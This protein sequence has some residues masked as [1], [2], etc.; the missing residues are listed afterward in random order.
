[1]CTHS[2]IAPY[3]ILVEL[4]SSIFFIILCGQFGKDF[5]QNNIFNY[6]DKVN[7]INK[8]FKQLELLSTTL[9]N[10]DNE[11]KENKEKIKI[12]SENNKALSLKVDT[13]STNLENKNNEIK[14]LKKEN[15][16]FK[17]L[18]N[19]FE[20]I[21]KRLVNFIK[22]KINKTKDNDK[23]IELSKRNYSYGIFNVKTVKNIKKKKNSNDETI[24][25][26]L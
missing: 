7:E 26:I 17:T 12:L 15:N 24:I 4:F 25:K 8:D 1:M 10:V 19:R 21:F 2:T 18:V 14:E 5:L 22:N 9:N 6:L 13:L 16:K 3:V 20:T 23:Y 11:L